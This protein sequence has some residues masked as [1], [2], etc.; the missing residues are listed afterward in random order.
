MF[1]AK[2]NKKNNDTSYLKIILARCVILDY[3]RK[4]F[5]RAEERGASDFR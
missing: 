2:L 4:D 3:I 1:K 5:F